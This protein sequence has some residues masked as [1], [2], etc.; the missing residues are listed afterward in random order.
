[1]A[2]LSADLAAAREQGGALAAQ[3]EALAGEKAGVEGAQASLAAQVAAL[4]GELEALR[5]D[6]EADAAEYERRLQVRWHGAGVGGW[7]L[8][9][10]RACQAAFT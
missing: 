4:Q 6:R 5:A 10:S 2:G 3:L 8:Q 1:M 9:C 7:A